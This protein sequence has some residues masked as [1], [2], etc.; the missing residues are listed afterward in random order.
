MSLAS[1]QIVGGELCKIFGLDRVK[2]MKI[3]L[4]RNSAVLFHVEQ[5]M[6]AEHVDGFLSVMRR[7]ELSEITPKGRIDRMIEE[8]R[9]EI[10]F[11]TREAMKR[12]DDDYWQAFKPPPPMPPTTQQRFDDSSDNAAAIFM[13]KAL[14]LTAASFAI[15][16][17]FRSLGIIL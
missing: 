15:A 7:F 13:L 11:L 2:S 9:F 6:K 12:I 5:Y 4:E 16:Y 1:G 10:D 17:S 8:A 14:I 3:E